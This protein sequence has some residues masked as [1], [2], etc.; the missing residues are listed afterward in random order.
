MPT[1]KT[2]TDTPTTTIEVQV[3]EPVSTTT[4]VD[5]KTGVAKTET[6]SGNA[7][8]KAIDAALDGPTEPQSMRDLARRH[9]E[10]DEVKAAYKRNYLADSP[11]E[12]LAAKK[13]IVE[14]SPDAGET[15]SGKALLAVADAKSPSEAGERYARIKSLLRWGTVRAEEISG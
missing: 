7:A 15:P 11:S 14:A 5:E 6:V 8:R 4:T 2:D 9:R 3:E 13:T 1:K 10:N 12:A